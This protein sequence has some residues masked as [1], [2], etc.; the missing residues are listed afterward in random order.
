M[1]SSFRLLGYCTAIIMVFTSP[2]LSA[3]ETALPQDVASGWGTEWLK[4]MH[5]GYKPYGF[6]IVDRK[7]GHPVRLG[8]KSIKFEVRPGD[9]GRNDD[10]D[11]CA[12]DRER[13]E[14]SQ[15]G[16]Y[17]KSGDEN[18]YAWSI[19]VP[20]DTA[21][22]WPTRVHLG[23]FNQKKNNV[24]WLFS[25]EPSGYVVDNQVPGDGRT[26]QKKLISATDKF[27]GQWVDVLIHAKWSSM[28]NGIFTVYTNHE[29]QYEHIGPNIAAGDTSFF[30]FGLYRSFLSR[31]VNASKIKK[32]PKQIVYYDEL[33][34]GKKLADVDRV[35][36]TGIQDHL[37]QAGLYKGKVDGQWG[38]GTQAAVNDYLQSKGLAPI[39]DYTPD[40]WPLLAGT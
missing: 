24:L 2:T 29:K 15:L 4:S 9:C 20:A 22:I 17:Q 7:S 40:L 8:N 37:A 25:W 38:K 19:F 35:G 28:D 18:W 5:R 10:W 1:T 14:L 26:K 23:Q 3:D 33:R 11:D 21:N 36:V 39:K 27:L 31:Y 30:K 6:Q 16:N 32:A 13:H 12:N 34:K